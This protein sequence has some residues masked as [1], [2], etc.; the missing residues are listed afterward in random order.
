M[1]FLVEG[2]EH[3]PLDPTH[4]ILP[5]GCQSLARHWE[6]S[7]LAA[8]VSSTSTPLIN[9]LTSP[10]SQATREESSSATTLVS[11]TPSTSTT[12]PESP[13]SPPFPLALVL[14][15]VLVAYL[16]VLLILIGVRYLLVLLI[17]IG[18]RLKACC[19]QAKR[20]W[21][22]SRSY[23]DNIF[24]SYI[25][26]RGLAAECCGVSDTDSTCHDCCSSGLKKKHDF[27]IIT[28]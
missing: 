13:D 9:L 22:S 24:R 27:V 17:L 14:S 3:I 12:P 25:T 4:A 16:L 1:S 2:L 18:V 15:C 5:S 26:R 6:E 21:L 11:L 10:L 28:I 23:P 8:M 20:S 19:H 7:F